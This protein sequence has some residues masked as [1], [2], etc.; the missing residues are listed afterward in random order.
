MRNYLFLLILLSASSCVPD[1]LPITIDQL[2]PAPVIWSQAVP[3]QSVLVYM[4]RTFGALE[5]DDTNEADST[6]NDILS[7]VL[8]SNALITLT[9]G[10]Q[11]DTLFEF[12]AGLYATLTANLVVGSE[13]TLH[14]FDP[15]LGK[16]IEARTQMMPTVPLDDIT[17]SVI[18]DSTLDV[19]YRFIDPVGQNYYAIHFYSRFSD[20]LEFNDPLEAGGVVQTELLS[21][22]ELNN[23]NVDRSFRLNNLDGDTL[24]V[25]LNNI[26]R[27]YYDYL[28][29]R[30]RS[31]SIFVQAV[32][33]PI[34]FISN[35]E[36]GYGIFSLQFPDIKMV[37]VE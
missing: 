12:T 9:G 31:G 28:Q 29:Q 16:R 2:E 26:S 20:P 17:Y 24:Y 27:T 6:G 13:Y 37:V 21:D 18:N 10:G 7:Q 30:K 11:T 3:G 15:L 25:S 1:P 22:L 19:H 33:E 5:Y 35:V 32:A 4:A 23:S 36:G 8:T 14:A 34:T